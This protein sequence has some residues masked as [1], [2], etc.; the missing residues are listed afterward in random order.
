MTV[1]IRGEVDSVYETVWGWVVVVHTVDG[2]T[3]GHVACNGPEDFEFTEITL[4]SDADFNR[5]V[6]HETR[7]GDSDG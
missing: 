4:C 1:T 2:Q 7:P 5:D 6:R 3:T